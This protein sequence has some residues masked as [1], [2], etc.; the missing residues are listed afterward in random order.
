[1]EYKVFLFDSE[2]DPE[3]A[4][5]ELLTTIY[6]K[7]NHR[8]V[9]LKDSISPTGKYTAVV[10]YIIESSTSDTSASRISDGAEL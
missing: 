6:T 4:L 3:E 5:E 2:R 10:H 9:V 8:L 7:A 1:M